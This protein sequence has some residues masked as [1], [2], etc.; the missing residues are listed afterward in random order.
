MRKVSN[1]PVDLPQ[2]WGWCWPGCVSA[3]QLNRT[4]V[5]HHRV[6]CLPR[7]GLRQRTAWAMPF[8]RQ[9]QR[10]T[11]LIRF[12]DRDSHK[13]K[14]KKVFANRH[15]Y[16]GLQASTSLY[17]A[18]AWIWC[19]VEGIR[20]RSHLPQWFRRHQAPRTLMCRHCSPTLDYLQDKHIKNISGKNWTRIFRKTGLCLYLNVILWQRRR[21]WRN[22]GKIIWSER[23]S[24]R[25]KSDS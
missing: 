20:S 21:R 6:Y 23:V 10:T 11:V 14:K 1:T 13:S 16:I 25:I 12:W 18:R 7:L 19:S 5:L 9:L 24:T 4:R 2:T 15:S 8:L 3:V 17:L 22:V